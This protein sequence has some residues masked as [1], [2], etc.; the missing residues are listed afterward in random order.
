[1]LADDALKIENVIM[2]FRI[3]GIND[4]GQ[5]VDIEILIKQLEKLGHSVD[6]VSVRISSFWRKILNNS[7]MLRWL[8]ITHD[9]NIFLER[10]RIEWIYS[11]KISIL[12]PNPEWMHP[13]GIKLLPKIDQIW[14]KTRHAAEIFEEMGREAKYLGF[15][16]LVQPFMHAYS[17]PRNW[18][19]FLHIGG[20]SEL[21]G[22]LALMREWRKH[23][24][25]PQLV[26][27][28]QI[29]GC[30]ELADGINNI[31]LIKQRVSLD[32]VGRLRAVNGIHIQMSETEGYGHVIS[33]SMAV[34]AVVVTLDA[35]PMN[36]LIT[37]NN[38]ILVSANLV[39][40]RDLANRYTLNG[41]DFEKKIEILLAMNIS[42]LEQLA[43]RCKNDYEKLQRKFEV[44][45]ANFVAQLIPN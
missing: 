29:D 24:G 5:A 34:G 31:K 4:S 26:V 30:H 22:T 9:V 10:P 38:G 7:H 16:S 15:T 17:E 1:M 40:S 14:C 19:G 43:I 44:V 27:L 6:V 36:E 18:R 2:H 20:K 23:P 33:E 11:A 13:N 45:F 3:I 32:E 21:K 28:S 42:D 8:P 37:S 12:I 25:W 39:G 35:A 41:I